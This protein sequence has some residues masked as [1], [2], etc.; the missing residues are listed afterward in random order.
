[1]SCGRELLRELEQQ[2]FVII[3]IFLLPI[4][5]HWCILTRC[6]QP[7]LFKI[8]QYVW[9][10]IDV[11]YIGKFDTVDTKSLKIIYN[12]TILTC[13]YL[14]IFLPATSLQSQYPT[15]AESVISI[16]G[17]KKQTNRSLG[18]LNKSLLN[19]WSTNKAIQ[20]VD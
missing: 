12:D 18:F 3:E 17:S 15:K 20:R 19:K 11:I 6:Y 2:L 9:T 10:N 7:K 8:K 14:P 16:T 13:P 5:I 1:M 4:F